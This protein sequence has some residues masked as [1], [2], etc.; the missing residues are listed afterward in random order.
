MPE[1]ITITGTGGIIEGNLGTSNVNVNLDAVYTFTGDSQYVRATHP[2]PAT[3]DWSISWWQRSDSN[4]SYQYPIS[5]GGG[6]GSNG[7]GTLWLS[8]NSQGQFEIY[9]VTGGRR[10]VVLESTVNTGSWHHYA[11]TVDRSANMVSYL[12]GK[13]ANTTDISADVGKSIGGSATVDFCKDGFLGEI[14]DVRIFDDL[15]DANE[16]SV[17]AT[18][19]NVDSALGPGTGNLVGHWKFVGDV[20]GTV[21]DSGSGSNNGTVNGSPSIKYDAFSVNVQDSYDGSD[22]AT[23][24]QTD[25]N[26]TVTQGKVEGLSL[27][28]LE[29]NGSNQEIALNGN[30]SMADDFTFSTWL[31]AD[32]FSNNV[33]LGKGS[34]ASM[35][36]RF[37]NAT[38]F[39]ANCS[40]AGAA[41]ITISTLP[42]N[43][44]LHF[45]LT[46]DKGSG[47]TKIYVNGVLDATQDIL[48]NQATGNF[49]Y[50]GYSNSNYFDGH[51]RDMRIY[52]GVILSADQIAS[53]YSG[54]Y[55]VMPYLWWKMD[56]GTGLPLSTGTKSITNPSDTGAN[57]GS[58][59]AVW[60]NG[61]LD[62]DGT[63]TIAANGTLSAP[64]GNLQCD[65]DI[66]FTDGTYTHNNGTFIADSTSTEV[67]LR[68]NGKAFYNLTTQGSSN[69]VRIN[70]L[71]TVEKALTLNRNLVFEADV[72]LTLGTSSQ[73]CTVSGSA[74]LWANG[75]S[76]PKLYGAS[77]LYP[78]I[79]TGSD[80]VSWNGNAAINWYLK[81]I[82]YRNSLTTGS[83]TV[84]I[85]LDGDCE[86]D[87][88]TVSSGDTL[89]LNGQRM[90]ATKID[91]WDGALT[92]TTANSM[93][94]YTGTPS[95]FNHKAGSN[96]SL[97]E[98]SIIDHSTLSA[99][100]NYFYHGS[101]S[102]KNYLHNHSGGSY[103]VQPGG[104]DKGIVTNNIIASPWTGYAHGPAAT[105]HL[106]G[107]N[108][109]IPTGGTMTAG[110][111]VIR[112]SGDFT[113]SGGLIG[114]S[115]LNTD[116]QATR[117]D[118]VDALRISGDRT[119]EFWMKHPTGNRPSAGN[120]LNLVYKSNY[121]Y[122][123]RLD[124]NGKIDAGII[125]GASTNV[126]SATAVDDGKW[127]HIAWVFDQSTAD[128]G[129][130]IYIDGK[131]DAQATS[132]AGNSGD[133]V[134]LIIGTGKANSYM[135]EIRFWD[136]VRTESEIRANMFT[137]SPSG[138][139]LL[140]HYK[141][142]EGTGTS[143]DD[144]V[145]SLDLTVNASGW[146]GAGDFDYDTST[147][148]MTGTSK[149]FNFL[150]G[151]SVYNLIINGTITLDPIDDSSSYLS[152]R[153]TTF[154]VGSSKTL[155][156]TG[157]L[158]LFENPTLTF[159]T[160][161]TNIS[162]LT[163]GFQNR[164]SSGTLSVPEVTVPKIFCVTSGGT[165]QA[166]GDLTITEELEVSSGTTFNANGN[167][168]GFKALD[169]NGTL[170]ISNSTAQSIDAN[171]DYI[172]FTG[173]TLLSGNSTLQGYGTGANRTE[174]T[175]PA[176]QN[177][178]LVGTAKW[179]D[180]AANADLTVVGAVIDCDMSATGA[181]IRQWHHTLDTQQLLDADS[182]G[183]DDLRLTKPALDNA[184]EL[185]TG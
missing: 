4:G 66:D 131:L 121:G 185:M 158:R 136:D 180:C 39:T 145:G 104:N 119:I 37:T 77:Q 133:A 11:V 87:A 29:F 2:V 48:V 127:H 140:V 148:T 160:P 12:D 8:D 113:T 71:F 167:T 174:F 111:N 147:L 5:N 72:V 76:S 126:V 98:T 69:S 70:E 3:G 144:A 97:T 86:F 175:A 64:R 153:G 168:I 25:G 149:T 107:T 28:S 155:S 32:E 157:Y 79:F 44:W 146:A 165:T 129:H 108:L 46:R 137:E 150:G 99:N 177:L 38:T 75:S 59:D 40:G 143:S 36:L 91:A 78:A 120:H 18:K 124:E 83:N 35:E 118:G 176:S 45:A 163:G 85:I 82:D 16:I 88:V 134:T 13:V 62:L 17:L 110:A 182:D 141:C 65:G 7:F 132:G 112:Q 109:T 84:D 73:Q 93:I 154:T 42:T 95:S 123:V 159:S 142:N 47:E 20:D 128:T 183:D 139:N 171:S 9:P 164:K 68:P 166:T 151:E 74:E 184:H 43:Q 31:N 105:Y 67:N 90:E 49:D 102:I 22:A 138:D 15:L 6:G 162:G 94:V 55:N 114:A 14:A 156:S 63:L 170:D 60:D 54:S 130:K 103:Y 61:T 51:L 27:S 125:S 179:L 106:D 24:T 30:N 50:I 135:D 100:I 26:F 96:S 122:S 58:V 117:A 116:H 56:E 80:I 181:N 178:E 152:I 57:A 10:Q 92:G 41:N 173:G 172:D 1:T 81:W 21:N 53:L 115:C 34:D 19:I 52:D 33:L 23:R 101:C 169:I 89:N 161:A